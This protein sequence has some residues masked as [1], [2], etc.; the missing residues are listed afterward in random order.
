MNKKI[1]ASVLLTLSMLMLCGCSDIRD[2]AKKA[3]SNKTE[4]SDSKKSE[5]KEEGN[6][7]TTDTE[8]SNTESTSIISEEE[9][10]LK[11]N[12]NGN[13]VLKNGTGNLT[14]TQKDDKS[15]DFKIS[16]K[17]D[18]DDKKID[19]ISGTASIDEDFATYKYEDGRI[20]SFYI[21]AKSSIEVSVYNGENEEFIGAYLPQ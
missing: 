19:E 17:N 18:E 1:K 3:K 14:I 15:F 13:Y 5:V 10:A 7:E 12:W 2:E 21:I 8:S 20:M 16:G 11:Y 4:V 9:G 6:N